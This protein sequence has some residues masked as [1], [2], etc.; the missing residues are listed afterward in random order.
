MSLTADG[1]RRPGYFKFRSKKSSMLW[2]ICRAATP[3][4]PWDFCG[5]SM[6]S[7]CLPAELQRVDHLHGVLKEHVVVL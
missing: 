5:Y 1:P 3:P 7:N 6:N 4:T 2:F